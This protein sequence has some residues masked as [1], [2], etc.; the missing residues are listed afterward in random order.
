DTDN[1]TIGIILCTEKNTTIVK[2]SVLNDSKQLFAS[3]YKLYLP[4]EEELV[5]ELEAERRQI[6]S[7]QKT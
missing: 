6:E 4:T 5:K 3:K 1:P 2:Y 7:E